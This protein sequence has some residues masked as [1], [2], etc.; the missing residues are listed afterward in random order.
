[1]LLKMFVSVEVA[2]VETYTF[3]EPE[4]SF[5]AGANRSLT[6]VAQPPTTAP[7]PSHTPRARVRHPYATTS[8]TSSSPTSCACGPRHACQKNNTVASAAVPS[9]PRSTARSTRAWAA[10]VFPCSA[11]LPD[12]TFGIGLYKGVV[13]ARYVNYGSL[14]DGTTCYGG[15]QAQG[16]LKYAIMGGIALKA[17]FAVF[18]MGNMKV[19]LANKPLLS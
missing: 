18:D 14:G 11:T 16:K 3:C 15:L 19:G 13:P 10:V 5:F 17:Q 8:R 1:M 7:T 4:S 2:D 9:T 12:F 6:A